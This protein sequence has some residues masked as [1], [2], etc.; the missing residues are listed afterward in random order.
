MF[1]RG[2]KEY[3]KKR[4][5]TELLYLKKVYGI[6]IEKINYSNFV[7]IYSLINTFIMSTIYII[8]MYLLNNLFLRII[9]G[10]ILLVLMIIICYGLLAKYYLW[11]E[12]DK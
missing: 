7:T 2:K 8:I 12:G 4:I 3:N 1:V 5:P 6:K 11:K 9:I 10:I